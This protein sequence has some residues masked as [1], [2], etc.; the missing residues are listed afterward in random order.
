M[1]ER[2]LVYA[3]ATSTLTRHLCNLPKLTGVFIQLMSDYFRGKPIAQ[4]QPERE[5]AVTLDQPLVRSTAAL[6]K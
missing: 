5:P 4:G 3:G 2:G 6:F 1:I